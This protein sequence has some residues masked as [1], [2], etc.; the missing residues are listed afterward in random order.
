MT[1]SAE[2]A[3]GPLQSEVWR[4]RGLQGAGAQRSLGHTRRAGEQPPHV[5]AQ[6]PISPSNSAQRR[7]CVRFPRTS[8]APLHSQCQEAPIDLQLIDPSNRSSQRSNGAGRTATCPLTHF[9]HKAYGGPSVHRSSE[10]L[11][12]EGRP[13]AEA[14]QQ[15]EGGSSGTIDAG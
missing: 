11:V 12:E 8:T 2:E 15:A 9:L 4:Q 3:D 10:K 5:M 1:G 6:N 14:G 7:P 13:G